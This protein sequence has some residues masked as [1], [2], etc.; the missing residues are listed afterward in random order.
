MR[1]FEDELIHHS[2]DAHRPADQLELRVVR[3]AEDE[4]VA[5]ESSQGFAADASGQLYIDHQHL[6]PSFRVLGAKDVQ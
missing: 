3:V 6:I 1:E 2:I 4:V 5:V